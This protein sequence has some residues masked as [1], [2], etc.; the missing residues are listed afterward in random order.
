M[1]THPLFQLSNHIRSS[2]CPAGYTEG[3]SL[4]QLVTTQNLGLG[5]KGPMLDLCFAS[6]EPPFYCT[7]LSCLWGHEIYG[8]QLVS[9]SLRCSIGQR[10]HFGPP[11]APNVAH[12]EPISNLDRDVCT[13]FRHCRYLVYHADDVVSCNQLNGLLEAELYPKP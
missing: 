1:Q 9:Y 2:R 5:A 10:C 3:F 12:K 4:S 7:Y 13:S 6:C 8:V 11:N